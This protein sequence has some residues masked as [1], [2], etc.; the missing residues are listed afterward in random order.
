[1]LALI[2]AARL[3]EPDMNVLVGRYRVDFLWREQRLIAETDGGGWHSSK[4]R[5]DSDHRRD[6]DLRAAG[7]TVERFTD[8]E[9][10]YEPHAAVARLARALYT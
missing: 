9:L 8:H 6:S 10:T 2:R 3:P 4:Q 5:R 7:Y 1:M